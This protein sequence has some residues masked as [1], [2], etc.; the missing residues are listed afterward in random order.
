VGASEGAHD[1]GVGEQDDVRA[2]IEYLS[3]L[4]I[5]QPDL[6]GYSFGAWVNAMGLTSYA[7]VDRVV[8]VSPPV[9]FLDFDE[10]KPNDKIKLV[11]VGSRDDIAQA[12]LVKNAIPR[13]NP[14]ASLKI[15]EGAD[16]FYISKTGELKAVIGEFLN[17]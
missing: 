11:I 10:L 5:E 9:G 6:A 17:G 2:A 1:N 15:I 12:E 3:N 7:Q 13:W 14:E 16:H 8:M 4:G